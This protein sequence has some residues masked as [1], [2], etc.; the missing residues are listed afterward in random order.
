MDHSIFGW[1]PSHTDLPQSSKSHSHLG[2]YMP[3]MPPS[4]CPLPLS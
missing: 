4:Q 2:C 1:D 3:Y